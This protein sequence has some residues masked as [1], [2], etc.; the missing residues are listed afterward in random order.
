MRLCA[1]VFALALAMGSFA[2]GNV[3]LTKGSYFFEGRTLESW[4]LENEFFR[5][6]LVPER[7][8][9]A[10][11]WID[12]RGGHVNLIYLSP[13]AGG[14]GGLFDDH[15]SRTVLPYALKVLRESPEACAV[16][17]SA[18]QDDVTYTK[19]I[20]VHAGRPLVEVTY[21]IS[22]ASQ[23]EHGKVLIRNVIRPGGGHFTESELYVMPLTDRVHRTTKG[24]GRSENIGAPWNGIVNTTD[25]RGVAVVYAGDKI[26]RFYTWTQSRVAPTYEWMF[27]PLAPG[28]RYSTTFYLIIAH[29]FTGYSDATRFYVAESA[30]QESGQRTLRVSNRL[31]PVW[32]PLSNVRLDLKVRRVGQDESL[33]TAALD[34]GNVVV[35]ETVERPWTWQAPSDGAYVLEVTVLSD[36]ERLGEYEEVFTVGRVPPAALAAYERKPKW[37]GRD[38]VEP[39]PGWQKQE[40]YTLKPGEA[41]KRA[42]YMLFQ[43]FG[44]DAGKPLRSVHVDMGIGEKESL[45]FGLHPITEIGKVRLRVAG[46]TLPADRVQLTAAELV[47]QEIWGKTHVGQKLLNT[48]ILPTKPGESAW[49][50]VILDTSGLAPGDYASIIRLEP[51]SAEAQTLELAVRVLPVAMPEDLLISFNPNSLFNYLAAS[52]RWPNM[53]WDERK[54]RLYAADM[55]AHGIRTLRAYA[56]NAPGMDPRRIRIRETGEPLLDAIR[57]NPARFRAGELPALDL[58]YWDPMINLA[59]EYEQFRYCTTLGNLQ[60][61]DRNFIQVSRMI[62]GDDGLAPDSEEHRRIRRWL[63]GQIP[64]YLREKGFRRILTTIAD[65]I[66]FDLFHTWVEK[67]K[68]AKSLGFAP[69]V[70]TSLLTLADPVHLKMLAGPSDYWIIGTLNDTLLDRA[71]RQ[72]HIEPNDWVETYCSSANFW[73][74]YEFMRRWAGWW[75]AFFELDAV[76]IQEYWRWKQAAAVIFPDDVNGPKSSGAWEGCRDGLE[77]ANYYLM[78]LDLVR[79]LESQPQTAELGRKARREL[80][81]IAGKRQ[82]STVRFAYQKTRTG[83]L[84]QCLT[85]DTHA[86]RTAKAALLELIVRYRDRL[87]HRGATVKWG[88]IA[89]AREGEPQFSVA[90]GRDLEEAAEAIREHIER[91]IGMRKC[92]VVG[93]DTALTSEGGVIA[94]V[95]RDDAAF[96]KRLA[97]SGIDPGISP[98]YPASGS[99]LIREVTLGGRVWIIIVGADRQ[100]ALL[101][102]KNACQFMR[103]V[104]PAF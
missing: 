14:Y 32:R 10:Y 69:G 50:W 41:E 62:F 19:R 88:E 64:L 97:D 81:G 104:R 12:K 92:R 66:P 34:L 100:G 57:R 17:L 33:Q 30:I 45:N 31:E 49:F 82:D 87:P 101:G 72:G 43:E 65:E 94:V 23:E 79:A 90:F 1:T 91:R 86:F 2:A 44:P 35:G 6:G 21:E 46:G 28:T 15:G 67:A 78:A 26:K 5:L 51:Q 70:T 77:D 56:R 4:T 103:V 85:L 75:P 40:R 3:R 73:Q 96:L 42:G 9:M 38:P 80:E 13:R 60:S 84:L 89:I 24:F 61:Y 25:R 27:E 7:G 53:E 102:A 76:W 98:T 63:L 52:G 71:R 58:S 68:E 95:S 22:N 39:V 93:L 11:E 18:T 59:L 8:G 29:G 37:R 47:P 16:E 20:T 54:G 99:Y 36:G 55:H 74:R 48:P 83:E